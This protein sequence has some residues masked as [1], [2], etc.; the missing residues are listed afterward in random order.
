MIIWQP[1]EMNADCANKLLKILEEPPA[2]TLFLLV[3]EDASKL[4]ITIQSRTQL[5]RVPKISSEDLST[6]LQQTKNQTRNNADAVSAFA[7]GSFLAALA[8]LETSENQDQQRN[9]FIQLMRVCYKKEVL[10]M[11]DWAD[12][13]STIGKERQKLFIQYTLHMLR[14]SILSNYMGDTLT[15]VSS[16]EAAFLEKF[17]PFIS[18][19]NIREFMTTLDAAY[20]QIDR[21]A[22]ARILFTQLCFQTMRYIHQA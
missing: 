7:D 1:E 20:Y 12:E 15:K 17:A 22:N 8:Y 10:A 16:E 19:N 5:I 4:M 14:Q 21:N 18:G 3:S 13:L 9:Q 11:M 6:N 2:Q